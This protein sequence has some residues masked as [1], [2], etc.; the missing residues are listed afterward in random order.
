MG[1]KSQQRAR[2]ALTRIAKKARIAGRE[3]QFWV[4]FFVTA[5]GILLLGVSEVRRTAQTVE[6]NFGDIKELKIDLFT[7]LQI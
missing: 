6:I 4:H 3:V 7:A 2:G 5:Q 1:T